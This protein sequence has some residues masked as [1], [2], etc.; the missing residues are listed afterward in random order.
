[1]HEQFIALSQIDGVV[2]S[3]PRA[4]DY[5]V[6]YTR[7]I[8][9]SNFWPTMARF[10]ISPGH[11]ML[12][13]PY[14]ERNTVM[15]ETRKLYFTQALNG[16]GSLNPQPEIKPLSEVE[17]NITTRIISLG[18]CNVACPYCKRD[19]QFIGSDGYPISAIP[20]AIEDVARVA[21]YAVEKGETVRFSGGDPVTMPKET[22]ALATWVYETFGVKSSIAHNGTGPRWVAKMA[23]YLSS[24]AIDLKAIPE[25][26]AGI[27]DLR[28][29]AGELDHAKAARFYQLSLETQR[30]L[31]HQNVLTDV[32]TPVFGDTN[33]AELVRLATDISAH[34][35]PHHTFWTWRLYKQVPGCD[36][37]VPKLDEVITM[38]KSVSNQF[39]HLWL[40]MR[41]KW[42]AG[43]MVYIKAGQEITENST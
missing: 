5:Q 3:L 37:Q 39:P 18:E 22:L 15:H 7:E 8:D 26:L 32:R 14:G 24:A 17:G 10:G 36:W 42:T 1:M 13:L 11:T 19:C 41:A 43:G 4:V 30:I 6:K 20:V 40:G 34:N 23:P 9:E 29:V 33:Q 21:A 2:A 31:S 35:S 28:T 12:M 16:H 27:M 25:K 38:M